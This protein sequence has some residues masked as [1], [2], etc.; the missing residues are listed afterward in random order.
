VDSQI[1]PSSITI[2]PAS[3]YLEH[4]GLDVHIEFE[5]PNCNG[6]VLHTMIEHAVLHLIDF[7]EVGWQLPCGWVQVKL[8]WPSR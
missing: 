3:G 7:D 1:H 6:R 2:L 8:P 5:C 4:G